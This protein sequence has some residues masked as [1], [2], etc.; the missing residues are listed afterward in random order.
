MELCILLAGLVLYA[1]YGTGGFVYLAVCVLVSYTLG[2]LTVKWKPASWLGIGLQALILVAVKLKPVTG[3][4]FIAP[5]GISYFTLRV[6][7]YHA[8]LL[9]GKYPP[10]KNLKHYALYVT[11]FPAMFLGPIES[12][13][14]F[15]SGLLGRSWSWDLCSRGMIRVLWGGMKKLVIAARA[16]VLI[17]TISASPEQYRGAYALFAMVLY[18]LQL[19]A[20]FSGGIDMVLGACNMLGLKFS[21]NFDLPFRAQ[22]VAEFWRRWHMTLGTWLREYIYIPLGGNRKGKL[23]KNINLVI[24]FFVSGL[25]HGVHYL[26]WGIFNGIFVALGDRCKTR[27]RF[28]NRLGT[29]LII[30]LLWAFFVWPE[31][32]TALRMLLSAFTVFNYGDLLKNILALG[33][34]AGEWI[35]LLL[36]SGLMIRQEGKSSY[37]GR[38]SQPAPVLRTVIICSLGLGIL[39]FGMYGIGFDAAAFIYSKF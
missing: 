34:N 33:L 26:L 2:L 29:G 16:G 27:I 32:G 25:W 4:E 18:S 30:S 9:R 36:G 20:D 13:D 38:Y 12:Y 3:M 8:D 21:E 23:R 14:R 22:T 15:R 24:T 31:T 10:V 7:S 28:L 5:L 35:V 19:Y 39:I 11:F 37:V 1:G 17:G 6:I